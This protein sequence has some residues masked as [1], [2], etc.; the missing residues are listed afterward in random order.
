[1]RHGVT[2]PSVSLA[3]KGQTSANLFMEH[4]DTKAQSFYFTHRLH[5]FFPSPQ[6]PCVTPGDCCHVPSES[7]PMRHGV[8]V[9]R[10]HPAVQLMPCTLGDWRPVPPSLRQRGTGGLSSCVHQRHCIS[11]NA[12]APG[13]STS[14]PPPELPPL[15][16]PV[17]SPEPEPEPV[18]S[19]PVPSEPLSPLEPLS[20][21]STL[22]LSLVTRFTSFPSRS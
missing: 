8:T 3:R 9:P 4:K 11:A 20:G 14:F 19:V 2:V 6:R 12:S 21:S 17:P 7:R 15:S 22:P 5:G 10:C 16:P 18:P 13:Q 1:M